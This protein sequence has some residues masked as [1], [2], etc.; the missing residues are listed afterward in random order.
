MRYLSFV[1]R[2]WLKEPDAGMGEYLV[3]GRIEHI[4]SSANTKLT[5]LDDVVA[6]IQFHL[7]TLTP[8]EGGDMD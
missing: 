1:V 8:G 4:Q 5:R 7:D 3:Y 6:F 2:L